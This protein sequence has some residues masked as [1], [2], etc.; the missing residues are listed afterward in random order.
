MN[1][2]DYG[3]YQAEQMSKDENQKDTQTQT[4]REQNFM[5]KIYS[6]CGTKLKK[7]VKINALILGILTIPTI[8]G[9]F[10]IYILYLPL[11][12]LAET[13][14][15]M[16]LIAKATAPQEQATANKSKQKVLNEKEEKLAKAKKLYE[17]GVITSEEYEALI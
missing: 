4:V 17:S 10:I 14:E 11:Y 7:I 13:T 12:C 6:N 1:K 2:L 5:D 16:A 3:E 8:I 9:P 15:N